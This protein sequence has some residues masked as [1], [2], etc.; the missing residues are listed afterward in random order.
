MRWDIPIV[1][2]FIKHIV[3]MGPMSMSLFFILSGF[4]LC[5]NYYDINIKTDYIDFLIKRF[6]RV[7]PIYICAAILTIPFITL[8]INP[9]YEHLFSNHLELKIVINFLQGIFLGISNIFILQ[10]W[11][12]GLFSYWNDGGSWSL[13]VEVFCYILFPFFILLFRIVKTKTLTY[14]VLL[15]YILTIL[16]GFAYLIFYPQ[17]LLVTIYALPIFR[18]PEFLIGIILCI[19]YREKLYSSVNYY[20]ILFCTLLVWFI[21]SALIGY[22]IPGYVTSNIIIIP[23]CSILI[24]AIANLKGGVLFNILTS[25]TAII[26]GE[27]SYC[28]YLLQVVPIMFFEKY[29]NNISK[30]IP[31]FG[32][33]YFRCGLT[34]ISSIIISILFHYKVEKV[35]RAKILN[36]YHLKYKSLD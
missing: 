28:L 17:P 4:I 12:P 26:L 14:L 16:P 27:S 18:L 10:G 15:F 13:S 36:K 7:Y 11:F 22:K 29:G 24:Y 34:I 30:S 5:Y 1:P 23:V 8:K 9:S 25:K 2:Q 32:D 21:Y 31:I 35:L 6:A 33:S 20:N 3:A 19:F